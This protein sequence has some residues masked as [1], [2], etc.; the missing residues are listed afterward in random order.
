MCVSRVLYFDLV[1]QEELN[2]LLLFSLFCFNE[3]S[4]G[5]IF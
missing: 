4:S 2:V 5:G 1:L 3:Q